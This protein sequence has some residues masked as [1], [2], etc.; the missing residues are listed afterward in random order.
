MTAAIATV[1][2]RF[3]RAII[4]AGLVALAM[5]S[6]IFYWGRLQSD[7]A[8]FLDRIRT[9][10][11]SGD[12]ETAIVLSKKA[13][14]TP[15][16]VK[17][18]E[19]VGEG[20]LKAGR[21]G[22]AI[23]AYEQLANVQDSEAAI[24]LGWYY[25][26]EAC[27]TSGR[28][29]HAR[30]NYLRFL[31]SVPHHPATHERLGFLL[32][33]SGH[34]W[35]AVEH[36]LKLAQGSGA[37]FEELSLLA[38]PERPIEQ[39]SHLEQLAAISPDDFLVRLGIAAHN[40]WEGRLAESRQALPALITEHPDSPVARALLGEILVGDND[41][42]FADWYRSLRP[43]H[44]VDPDI[45]YIC[46]LQARR[47]GQPEMAARCFLEAI[48][49]AP[50]HRRST[51]QLAQV[52]RQLK[53]DAAERV[54]A[55]ARDFTRLTQELDK[56]LLTKGESAASFL[57]ITSTLERLGRIWEAGAWGLLAR[58][59]FPEAAWHGALLE[60]VATLL[61]PDLPLVLPE[62]DP[63]K[64]LDLSGFPAFRLTESETATNP[65]TIAAS[66]PR[67]AERP[68]PFIYNNG[69]DP[70][71]AGARIFE[72][73]GGGVAVLDFD[74]DGHSDLFLTQGG[75]W[76]TGQHVPDPAGEFTD[77]LF[78]N[79]Q[80]E[81]PID[82][83][84]RAMPADHGY[85]QGA[86]A[87]DIDNDGFPDLYIGNIGRNQLLLNNG[88]GT[89]RDITE[90]SGLGESDWTASCVIADLDGDGAPDLFDTNYLSGD[91]IYE[92]ICRGKSCSPVGFPG[93]PDRLWKAQGDGKFLLV[94]PQSPEVDGK[95][96]GI[97]VFRESG[98]HRPSL[99]IANDQV[100]NFL[101]RNESAEG[102]AAMHWRDDAFV[103]GV[104]F[105]QNGLAMASMGIAADDANGDGRIDFYVTTFREES[106]MLLIQDADGQ[107][108]DHANEAGLYSVTWPFVGWG[109]QFLDVDRDGAVDL[110]GVNG[111]VD[112]YRDQGGEYQMR[113]HLLMNTGTG[114][115]IAPSDESIGPF[116]A[117]KRLGRGLSRLDWDGDGRMDFAVSW[118]GEQAS[119]VLNQTTSA[120]HW[121]SLKL[122][123]T[124]SERDA[125]GVEVEVRSDGRQQVRQL[126]AG[127]G[128]MASNERLLQFGL[129]AATSPVSILVRWPSGGHTRIPNVPVDA[130]V[131]VVEGREAVS[132]Q[133]I[134]RPT[135]QL[136]VSN[137]QP[138]RDLG[139]S[140]R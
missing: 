134:G 112:D 140:A 103:R 73:N 136:P 33:A 89:F 72:Q 21:H 63:G 37:T 3:R 137:S 77:R 109:T 68:L 118:I 59:R 65:S 105:N 94:P 132:W 124:Q 14:G 88:D 125:I 121:V 62:V 117:R 76:T 19:L 135:R 129:G 38:D 12:I 138:G 114:R 51:I 126:V 113:S 67:F 98:R 52:L 34:R 85:G 90:I 80:S 32:S 1:G 11:A 31:E 139:H 10:I 47:E 35:L 78:R 108:S 106:S 87:G 55:R 119:L 13:I 43:P 45:H 71:T 48:R 82:V 111:H 104:A 131:Q 58:E 18:L 20:C 93:A 61:R 75:S 120:N 29:T 84:T 6:T 70:A 97:I 27:R 25:A 110:V 133:A 22:E 107:F 46:G 100:P 123:A 4:V 50:L 8:T 15:V 116:F 79:S 42:R 24:P 60:R 39:R 102:E 81:E 69:A 130:V 5:A 30:A 7:P 49:R 23:A 74:R 57:E 83:T 53:H 96:L 44:F 9:A 64:T 115:F 101:W 36:F 28:W 54:E 127:D 92:K 17:S 128:Y 40:F 66:S 86:A 122:V 91:D 26:A 95:G 16:A 41:P 99:F 2:F 56:A